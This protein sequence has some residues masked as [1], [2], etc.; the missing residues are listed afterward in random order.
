M[1]SALQVLLKALSNIEQHEKQYL[2]SLQTLEKELAQVREDLN[3]AL[4][5]KQ[6]IQNAISKLGETNEDTSSKETASRSAT[7]KKRK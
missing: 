2:Q 4:T 6:E 5:A 7:S 3:L 1:N